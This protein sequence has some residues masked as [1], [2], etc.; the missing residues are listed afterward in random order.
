[1]VQSSYHAPWSLPKRVK[2]S[3]H[4][5]TYTLALTAALFTVAK[6]WNQ[7]RRSSVGEW[8]SK[9]WLKHG[10]ILNAYY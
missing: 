10:G 8:I 1:M 6:T 3:V 4:T 9:L 7:P 2:N 5:K